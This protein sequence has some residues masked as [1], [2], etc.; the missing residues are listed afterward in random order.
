MILICRFQQ[1]GGSSSY[2]RCDC[3][4]LTARPNSSE[5][6]KKEFQFGIALC[7]K[8]IMGLLLVCSPFHEFETEQLR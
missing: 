7:L 2:S 5:S 3:L 8:G 1:Q 6:S 4:L